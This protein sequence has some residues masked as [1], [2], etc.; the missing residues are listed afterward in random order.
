MSK[1]LFLGT[2]LVAL[3][4]VAC[5]WAAWMLARRPLDVWVWANRRALA[6]A[7]LKKLSVPSPAGPQ[8][9]FVGGSGPV[10]VLL[11]GAGDQAATW[12]H[13]V[14]SLLKRYTLVIPDLAGHGES[15]PPAGLIQVAD[16][17]GAL[18]AVISSQAPGQPV[19]IIGNSLG[20]WMGMVLANR[21]PSWVARVVAVNGGPLLGTNTKVRMLPTNREEARETM[22]Q[23]RDAASPAIPDKVLDQMV[24]QGPT[25]ALAR[26]AASAATMGEWL[27]SEEQLRSLSIPVRLVWG[28][29]DQLMPLDYARRMEAVLPDV[30]LIPVERCGHIPQQEAPER[31]QAAL[32]QAL[33]PT[34]TK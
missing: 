5:A 22:A 4:I 9:V 26:F 2:V 21:H 16:I 25:G 6:S 19:T 28:V 1:G 14:P 13:V 12:A 8:T 24:R 20:A 10:L 23:L 15:A 18:E 33:A 3:L 34:V 31:F 17:F 32:D 27:L 30:A 11:H 29:S 7:G